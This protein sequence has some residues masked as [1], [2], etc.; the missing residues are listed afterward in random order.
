MPSIQKTLL[1]LAAFQA[2]TALAAPVPQLGGEG[3]ACGSIL[4]DT[5]NAVG[6]TVEDVEDG[7]ANVVS[8]VTRRQL[9]G[10]GS[11]CDSI[12]SDTDN[13]VGYGIE[14]A[15]DNT[16]ALISGSSSSTTTT[17]GSGAA[18]PPPPPKKGPKAR[19]QLDKIAN[20]AANIL[21]AAHLNQLGDVVMTVG[22][23][24]DGELTSGAAKLGADVGSFE[25]QTLEG[26][27]KAIPRK[28]QL[29]KIANGAAN[30]LNA[31]HLNDL[32]NIVKTDGD[33]IDGQLTGD[34][35]DIGAQVGGLEEDTLEGIGSAVGKG[36]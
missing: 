1:L 7:V 17:G 34:A 33:N 25:E 35:A 14:N 27:G 2:F 13:A 12:V 23:N 26:V 30:I 16:A 36:L 8:K 28:R 5:D 9:A 4:T 32:A 11:A 19:R 24:V 3:A 6:Y 21:D 22:D 29:D 31:A 18:P 20:G 10:V 15:E